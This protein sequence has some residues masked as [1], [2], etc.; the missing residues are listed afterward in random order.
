MLFWP[1]IN[2]DHYSINTW[3]GQA[4]TSR[5]ER[6]R[7][8]DR[9]P[10]RRRGADWSRID[11]TQECSSIRALEFERYPMR[12]AVTLAMRGKIESE[13]LYWLIEV[14]DLDLYVRN[15]SVEAKKADL[16]ARFL[17]DVVTDQARRNGWKCH[18]ATQS[19]DT[20]TE[21]RL[22]ALLAGAATDCVDLRGL[23]RAVTVAG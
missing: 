12:V 19:A 18:I 16:T 22:R 23:A 4:K 2:A 10:G 8:S 11:R 1:T 3:P 9:C 14:G 7:E 13:P 21:K 5:G 20:V 17:P 6:E 15:D